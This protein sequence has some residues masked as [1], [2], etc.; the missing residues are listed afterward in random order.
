MAKNSN[1]ILLI[2]PLYY[3]SA[4]FLS[5][6]LGKDLPDDAGK[7]E[8][9]VWDVDNKYYTACLEWQLLCERS[10]W[11]ERYNDI[12]VVVYV[13]DG[14]IPK[15]LPSNLVK[16]MAEPRDIALAVRAL[17]N[18]PLDTSA[19]DDKF[20]KESDVGSAVEM[21]GEIGLEFIDEVNPLTDED[22]ER[23]MKP[24]D[25]IRQTLQTHMWPSLT[26]KLPNSSSY[27]SPTL[28][29]S[30][31]STSIPSPNHAKFDVTFDRSSLSP[32]RGAKGEKGEFPDVQE[33]KAAIYAEDFA[34]VDALDQFHSLTNHEGEYALL[35]DDDAMG[36][37]AEEYQILED[38]FEENDREF[39]PFKLRDKEEK[40]QKIGDWLKE[41]NSTPQSSTQIDRQSIEKQEDKDN[42]S[43][44]DWL[45][46]DDSRFNPI[47]QTS[48]KGFENNFSDL[49]FAPRSMSAETVSLDP[50]PLLSHLQTVRSELSNVQDEDE[51][52]VRAGKAVAH[53][54]RTLGMDVG[55][56]DD[57]GLD[58]FD[59]QGPLSTQ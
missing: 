29:P 51:K 32:E 45:E 20:N 38:W 10:D 34:S 56:D 44:G 47:L 9:I 6:L 42:R 22:D 14:D 1:T 55:E 18:T 31:V 40:D 27:L 28:S 3:N 21:F 16:F 13:F 25:I 54:L 19:N 5:R 49:Q 24:L 48:T 23:P 37:D 41:D 33:L 43:D 12:E 35:E 57:L 4:S 53:M 8:P 2:H 17:P 58:D 15:S 11:L 52:R 59:I 50:T 39:Q 46:E 7:S 30:S 36:P 26:R